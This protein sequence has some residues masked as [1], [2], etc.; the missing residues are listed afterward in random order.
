MM[1]RDE[2]A[3]G[4]DGRMGGE[5]AE[6]ASAKCEIRTIP[7]GPSGKS[8]E[9]ESM[10]KMCVSRTN[11]SITAPSFPVFSLPDTPVADG[12]RLQGRRKIAPGKGPVH[13]NH[14]VIHLP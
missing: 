12:K 1:I 9:I 11:R 3:R 8:I 6:E 13:M 2:T 4:K 14:P 10:G 7:P 5:N